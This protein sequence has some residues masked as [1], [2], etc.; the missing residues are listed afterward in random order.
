[1]QQVEGVVADASE[2]VP[3]E[4]FFGQGADGR[5]AGE[6]A[7][8]AALGLL[9]DLSDVERARG[10]SEYIFNNRYIRL[11]S[12]LGERLASGEAAQR[13]EGSELTFCSLF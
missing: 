8:V 2:G 1:V 4:D 6:L 10:G 5:F 12:A 3:V 7:A 9:E 11:A 13:A